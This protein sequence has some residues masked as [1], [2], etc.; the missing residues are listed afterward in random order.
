[1]GSGRGNDRVEVASPAGRPIDPAGRGRT[2]PAQ[3]VDGRKG[4]VITTTTQP[5]ATTV[6]LKELAQAQVDGRASEAVM[7]RVGANREDWVLGLQLQRREV[8]ETLERLRHT[9]T[10]PE[11]PLVLEDFSDE[12]ARIEAA[13]TVL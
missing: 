2:A 12:L 10:G 7:A 11:R 13:L 6:E 5:L 1:R 4:S 9:V 3:Q 8:E